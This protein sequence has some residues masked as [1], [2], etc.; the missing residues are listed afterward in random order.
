MGWE[1]GKVY[2]IQTSE[3]KKQGQQG[4]PWPWLW[5]CQDWICHSG[6]DFLFKKQLNT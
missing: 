1:G 3:K 2:T 6:L 5:V 4:N